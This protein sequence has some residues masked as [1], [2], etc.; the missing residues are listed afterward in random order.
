M[1]LA[2]VLVNPAFAYAEEETKDV[3]AAGRALDKQI[4]IANAS[5]EGEIDAAFE[6]LVE[7]RVDAIMVLMHSSDAGVAVMPETGV[8]ESL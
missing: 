7:R 5:T 8:T 6:S 3:L 2:G 1:G 4:H